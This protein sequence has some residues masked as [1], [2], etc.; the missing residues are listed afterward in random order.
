M[1]RISLADLASNNA[2]IDLSLLAEV[3]SEEEKRKER[4]EGERIQR[5]M[6]IKAQNDVGYKVCVCVCVCMY[7]CVCVC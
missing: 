7:V 4:M 2:K 5:V 6:Q 1:Q 3:K